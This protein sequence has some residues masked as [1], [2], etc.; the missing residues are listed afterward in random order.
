MPRS[1][2]AI[3]REAAGGGRLSLNDCIPHRRG[4]YPDPLRPFASTTVQRQQS[5]R[6]SPPLQLLMDSRSA[7]SRRRVRQRLMAGLHRVLDMPTSGCFPVME[8]LVAVLK[9]DATVSAGIMDT[10]TESGR[11]EAG[12]RGFP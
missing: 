7:I 9:L 4:T 11:L 1:T 12:I 8:E 3:R 5:A 2:S 6:S 10:A